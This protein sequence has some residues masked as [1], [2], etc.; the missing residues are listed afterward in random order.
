MI[1]F[2]YCKELKENQKDSPTIVK[3]TSMSCSAGHI[4]RNRKMKKKDTVCARRDV[5]EFVN[6]PPIAPFLTLAMTLDKLH[7]SQ[8]IQPG[9]PSG[10][11]NTPVSG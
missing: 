10:F 11:G 3:S 7:K 1:F 5:V 8:R 4:L 2:K 6:L 9:S